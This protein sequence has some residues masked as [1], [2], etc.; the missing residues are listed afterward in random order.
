MLAEKLVKVPVVLVVEIL[1]MEVL[2]VCEAGLVPDILANVDTNA[3]V[4]L[5]DKLLVTNGR[6]VRV[7]LRVILIVELT[8]VRE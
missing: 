5:L 2:D 4:G 1:V 3:F 7:M 6:E 8:N